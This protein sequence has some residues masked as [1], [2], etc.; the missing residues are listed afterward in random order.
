MAN[1]R[2]SPP[3]SGTVITPSTRVARILWVSGFTPAELSSVGI[4]TAKLM[5]IVAAA[6]R[7][8]SPGGVYPV[9]K[10][11]ED[12]FSSFLNQP[13]A[14]CCTRAGSALGENSYVKSPVK[15]LWYSVA[16]FCS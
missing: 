4:P 13:V 2:T 16:F 14:Y 9:N 1:V 3:D 12:S 10:C 6:G 11:D 7:V 8:E 15:Q 5:S